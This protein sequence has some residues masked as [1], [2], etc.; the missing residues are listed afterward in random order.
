MSD[1]VPVSVSRDAWI[2]YLTVFRESKIHEFNE[3]QPFRLFQLC[4]REIKH[5]CCSAQE[6]GQRRNRKA[7]E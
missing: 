2:F 6:K 4:F 1:S 3:R 5:P 7:E